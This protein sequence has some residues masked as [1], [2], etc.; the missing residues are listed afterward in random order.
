[1]SINL[2]KMQTT[3]NY[4]NEI[5]PYMMIMLCVVIIVLSLFCVHANKCADITS[6]RA[7]I[8]NKCHLLLTHD[9]PQHVL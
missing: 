7:Y 3:Q 5:M 1:M 8:H 2:K 6:A 4:C 9:L